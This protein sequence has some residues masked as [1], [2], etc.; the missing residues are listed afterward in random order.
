MLDLTSDV[1]VIQILT[2]DI[3]SSTTTAGE[4]VDMLDKKAITFFLSATAYTDGD[5]ELKIEEGDESD[6]SDA[7]VVSDLVFTAPSVGAAVSDGD[8]IVRN[9]CNLTKRYVRASV[10]STSVS[11]GATVFLG[12]ITMPCV[13]PVAQAS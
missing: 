12:A 9:G 7:A 3:A 6:L 11:S 4:I 2:G 1:N 8:S 5:Y 13:L 10:V